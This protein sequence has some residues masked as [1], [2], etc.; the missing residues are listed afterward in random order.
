[1]GSVS[2]CR[3]IRWVFPIWKECTVAF[4]HPVVFSDSSFQCKPHFLSSMVNVSTMF[5]NIAKSLASKVIPSTHIMWDHLVA[6]GGKKMP[7]FVPFH[8]A[9]TFMM[10]CWIIIFQCR[11]E[12]G[13]PCRVALNGTCSH[14]SLSLPVILGC[15]SSSKQASK[16]LRVRKEYQSD[17]K[18]H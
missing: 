3:T 15:T 10:I 1:M 6:E 2:T 13:A 14:I 9:L 12:S 8:L 11:M 17:T 16:P 5:C 4:P 7:K 18:K